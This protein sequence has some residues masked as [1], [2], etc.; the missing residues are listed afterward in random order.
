MLDAERVMPDCTIHKATEFLLPAFLS[1]RHRSATSRLPQAVEKGSGPQTADVR[2][3]ARTHASPLRLLD[4]SQ[5]FQSSNNNSVNASG[6]KHGNRRCWARTQGMAVAA[7]HSWRMSGI[8][9]DRQIAPDRRSR[10]NARLSQ[11]E[12]SES[13]E[14]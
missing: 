9:G 10:L 8:S 2:W 7:G 12:L 4:A 13:G 14:S 1:R 5:D 11:A 6:Q 3:S